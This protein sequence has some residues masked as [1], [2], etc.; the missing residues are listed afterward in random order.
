MT[1]NIGKIESQIGRSA[2][3]QQVR[4]LLL[5]QLRV[6]PWLLPANPMLFSAYMT[7]TMYIFSPCC[8]A[9]KVK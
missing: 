9:P 5:P 6:P 7:L 1:T 4:L 3:S 2:S 8:Y